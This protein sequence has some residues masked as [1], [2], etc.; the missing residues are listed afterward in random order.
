VLV[1]QRGRDRQAADWRDEHSILPTRPFRP[2]KDAVLAE[3]EALAGHV[4]PAGHIWRADLQRAVAA[5]PVIR[6]RLAV[7]VE[8]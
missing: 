6:E 3:Y 8:A 2:E 4:T 7:A 1:H 5:E